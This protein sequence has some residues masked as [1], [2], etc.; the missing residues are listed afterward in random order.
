MRQIINPVW[1]GLAAVSIWAAA[2]LA[3]PLRVGFGVDRPP[4]VIEKTQ[5][6]VEVEIVT[7]AAAK[8]GLQ[9]IPVFSNL[10]RAQRML[11]NGEIGAETSTRPSVDNHSLFLSEPYIEYQDC[12]FSLSARQLEVHVMADLGKYSVSSFQLAHQ[13]L[14]PDFRAMA[15]SNPSYQ[16]YSDEQFRTLLLY[17][18]RVDILVGDKFIFEYFRRKIPAVAHVNVSQPVTVYPLWP[19]VPFHVSFTRAD[20]RNRF[21]RGLAALRQSGEYAA[22]VKKYTLQ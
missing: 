3:E 14:G 7:R 16:E 10:A 15:A 22:I 5:S 18:G 4:Y 1:W 9:V 20:L 6:G 19:P 13:L 17:T 21:D 11:K 2:V 8:A 12:A